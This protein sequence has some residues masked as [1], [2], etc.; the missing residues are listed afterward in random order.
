MD[1]DG[2]A[3]DAA[4]AAGPGEGGA[5]D[6]YSVLCVYIFIYIRTFQATTV[7]LSLLPFVFL[8]YSGGRWTE[9]L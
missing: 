6:V 7:A 8:L 9:G 3:A 4:I 1:G 5:L 2:R